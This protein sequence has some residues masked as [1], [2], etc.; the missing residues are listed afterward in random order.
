M[1]SILHNKVENPIAQV[2]FAH[3]AG[4]NM[5]HGFMDN[6]TRLLNEQH[7]N[8]LR[9]NFPFMDKRAET[10]KR[11]PPDRMPKLLVC[12][13]E[14]INNYLATLSQETTKLPLFIGGK[15]M[16]SRV[17]STLAGEQE[18][19]EHIAGVFCIGYPFHPAKKIDKLRLEPLQ[20]IKKPVLILQGDRDPLGSQ[21][22]IADYEISHFCQCKFFVD[23]DHDLK[24]RV[25]SGYKHEQHLN[26]AA[27]SIRAFID[28][29]G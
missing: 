23:G 20:S 22:E 3:G 11:Y 21:A 28:E 4:A 7:I 18:N 15:S 17:A 14:V 10:G 6:F 9:F 5:A 8:V 2:I 16:G 12:Y 27:Q 1:T 19:F 25:K 24:P 26:E 29:H 13:Q